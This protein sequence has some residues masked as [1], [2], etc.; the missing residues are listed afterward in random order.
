K[1]GGFQRAGYLIPSD[2]KASGFTFSDAPIPLDRRDVGERVVDQ[3]NYLLMDR[4][5][6]MM[7]WFDRMA[8]FGPM[9]KQALAEEK[10]PEDLVYLCAL[11]SDMLPNAATR[12]GGVGWW[13]LGSGRSRN[14]SA[15]QW[16]TT[17]DWDDRR[18]PVISTKIAGRT[19]RGLL[20]KNGNNDWLLTIAAFLDGPDAVDT[21]VKKS[22]GFFFWDLVMPS[23]SEQVIPRLVALK[24]IET[25]RD[26]YAVDVP[27]LSPLDYDCLDQLKLAKDLPLHVVA[28]W[29]A[30]NPRS[31]WELN[32]GVDPSSGVFPKADKRSPNGFPLRVPKGKGPLVQ[33]MLTN[34]GYMSK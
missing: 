29:C 33:R 18:D 20:Q 15:P 22:P 24:L 28:K 31:M 17:N 9:I 27:K 12:S 7:E 1:T 16:V 8:V 11:V 21:I 25:H 19:L 32:P 4:R 5:A 6:S 34:E 3:V 13:A 2:V 30:T 26:F 10:V 23:Y 14:S